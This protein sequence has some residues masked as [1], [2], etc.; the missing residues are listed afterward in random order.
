MAHFRVVTIEKALCETKDTYEL[1][2]DS[3]AQ[4]RT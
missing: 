4:P 2:Q 1:S 3:Q